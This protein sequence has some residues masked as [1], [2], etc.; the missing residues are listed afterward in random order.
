MARPRFGDRRLIQTVALPNGAATV[1]GAGIHVG[2]G[3]PDDFSPNV[4]FKISAPALVVGDL[5]N[6]ATMKYSLITADDDAFTVNLA[7]L[8]ADVITQTGAGGAG[9][10]A[11]TWQGRAPIGGVRAFIGVQAIN[12][13]AGDASDKSATLELLV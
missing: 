11:A 13:A 9:A 6:G 10:A 1:K 12:S 3:T 4:E 5:G 8:I 7:V 2:C